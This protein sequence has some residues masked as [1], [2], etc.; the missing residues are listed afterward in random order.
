M[1]RRL[2]AVILSDFLDITVDILD[3]G[4]KAI[5]YVGT[6][7]EVDFSELVRPVMVYNE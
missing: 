6:V 2:A 7:Y 4:Y 1:F 3:F 5:V